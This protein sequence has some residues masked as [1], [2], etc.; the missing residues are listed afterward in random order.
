MQ[1]LT[2]HGDGKNIIQE[3][4]N[5]Y[6]NSFLK[7]FTFLQETLRKLYSPYSVKHQR[8]CLVLEML[9]LCSKRIYDRE[10]GFL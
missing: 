2:K 6:F 8:T 9:C 10:K 7:C 3:W 5:M 1:R 4:K